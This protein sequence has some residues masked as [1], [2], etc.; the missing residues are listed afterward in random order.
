MI[1]QGGPLL[2]LMK[3]SYREDEWKMSG[4]KTT[5]STDEK[6]LYIRESRGV[7]DELKHFPFAIVFVFI[8][9]SA[10]TCNSF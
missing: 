10:L 6:Q 1:L 2:P 4:C 3:Y 9:K 8:I 5:Y 7:T